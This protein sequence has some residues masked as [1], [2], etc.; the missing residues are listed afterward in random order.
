[1]STDLLTIA[2]EQATRCL[3]LARESDCATKIAD[4]QRQAREWENFARTVRN[5]LVNREIPDFK[6]GPWR[7]SR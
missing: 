5:Q 7:W 4:M 2:R 1:M 6:P 3:N